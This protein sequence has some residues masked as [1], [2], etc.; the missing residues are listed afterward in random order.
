M[1]TKEQL[2]LAISLNGVESQKKIAKL[3]GVKLHEFKNAFKELGIEH[4]PVKQSQ[5]TRDLRSKNMRVRHKD[6]EFKNRSVSG[7]RAKAKDRKG[8]TYDEIFGEL[9]KEIK[10]SMS[11]SHIGK[12]HSQETKDTMSM[13]RKGRK[14]TQ[15]HRNNISISRISGFADGRIKL[16]P[17][18]GCGKGGYR[19]D[20]GHYVRSSYEHKFALALQTMG[21]EYQYEHKRYELL[22]E[23][24]EY[25]YTPDFLFNNLI[26][27]I[28]NGYN[29]K[30]E[31]YLKKI[32]AMKKLH[33][34]NIITL[35]GDDW[36]E[37]TKVQQAVK[38]L[39]HT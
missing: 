12:R 11:L 13:S 22:I 32:D 38:N 20:I 16:S 6:E 2:E 10:D 14:F 33:G 17:K 37:P 21:I 8:K 35:I 31:M 5:E 3:L 34:I 4:L 28:K 30:D 39:L 25:G 15:E 27:D 19:A 7:F 24:K 36:N 26:V 29:S 1:L 18:A 9:A 23:G